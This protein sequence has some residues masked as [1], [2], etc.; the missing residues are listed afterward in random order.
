MHISEKGRLEALTVAQETAIDF[1]QCL[2]KARTPED[3]ERVMAS[4]HRKIDEVFAAKLAESGHE[5]GCKTGCFYCCYIK[6]DALPLEVFGLASYIKQHFSAD[7]IEEIR[8]RARANREKIA[9]LS[10]DAQKTAKIPCPLLQ[11]GRCMCYKARPMICRRYYSHK[12]EPCEAMFN[13]T[14]KED[15]R[16]QIPE[17]TFALSMMVMKIQDSLEKSGFDAAPYDLSS[18]LD[19]AL[20]NPKCYKRWRQGKTAFDKG[21]V[22]KDWTLERKPK[23]K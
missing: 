14:A 8:A 19:E 21:I 15:M 12:V 16:G 23:N 11:D 9:A 2:S 22:A 3:L 4:L 1:E 5:I 18:A 10:A 13:G 7:Q 20:N 17:L 6:V